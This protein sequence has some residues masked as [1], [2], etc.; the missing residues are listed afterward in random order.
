M[1]SSGFSFRNRFRQLYAQAR[2]HANSGQFN[3]LK[4]QFLSPAQAALTR[5]RESMAISTTD[6][7]ISRVPS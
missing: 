7:R 6:A 5:R 3:L 1:L 2:K 4:M